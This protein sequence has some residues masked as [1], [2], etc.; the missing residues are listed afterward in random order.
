MN[1]ERAYTSSQE[2][3]ANLNIM[4][5]VCLIIIPST[6]IDVSNYPSSAFNAYSRLWCMKIST[7]HHY[8]QLFNRKKIHKVSMVTSYI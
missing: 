5:V 1:R 4:L 2:T 3:L 7:H 6:E 8:N